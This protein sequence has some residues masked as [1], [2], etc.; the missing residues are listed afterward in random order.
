M[1]PRADASKCICPVHG[2][3]L[4]AVRVCASLLTKD[5]FWDSFENKDAFS[6]DT[7]I[8]S[9]LTAT[10]PPPPSSFLLFLL[11]CTSVFVVGGLPYLKH[12][13][14]EQ[15][16]SNFCAHRLSSPPLYTHR[17]TLLT[18]LNRSLGL[19]LSNKTLSEWKK[20]NKL[21]VIQQIFIF[22]FIFFFEA[23]WVCTSF[24]HAA[25]GLSPA[26]EQSAHGP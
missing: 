23:T 17:H 12:S 19:D 26:R 22:L 7:V 15:I 9:R 2:W 8:C 25:V 16:S 20:K 18:H 3:F 5:T 14:R 11:F 24:K 4:L 10:E 1:S 13:N 6:K 21:G